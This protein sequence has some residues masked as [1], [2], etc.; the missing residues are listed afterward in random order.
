M[1]KRIVQIF[2]IEAVLFK[3]AFPKAKRLHALEKMCM[4]RWSQRIVSWHQFCDVVCVVVET[5][6]TLVGVKPCPEN[7]SLSVDPSTKSKALGFLKSVCDP[8][9]IVGIHCIKHFLKPLL[10]PT[11]LLQGR[12]L[13][14]RKGYEVVSDAIAV[15]IFKI[16]IFYT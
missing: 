10:A 5:L 15:S 6:E 2:V 11:S 3:E 12:E 8:G 4:T 9:F 14:I 1:I 13:D 16:S 7:V